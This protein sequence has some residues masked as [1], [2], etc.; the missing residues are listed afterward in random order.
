MIIE[1]NKMYKLFTIIVTA[2]VFIFIALPNSNAQADKSK[3]TFLKIHFHVKNERRVEFMNIMQNINELMKN[4]QGFLAAD[5][6]VHQDDPNKITLIEKWQT[7]TLH[8]Q[9]YNHIVANGSWAK[10]LEMQATPPEM[11]YF[12]HINNLW[13]FAKSIERFDGML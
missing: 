13:S 5:V 10:I 1:R 2:I 6:Y 11:S 8:V 7:R 3:E 12:T 4:E 9:H